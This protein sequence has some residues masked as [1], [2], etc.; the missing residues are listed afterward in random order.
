MPGAQG[1]DLVRKMRTDAE[2][3]LEKSK[4]FSNR[5][6]GNKNAATLFGVTCSWQDFATRM[7]NG[8]RLEQ[9]CLGGKVTQ[10]FVQQLLN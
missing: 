4:G 2:E 3:M 8:K 9:L 5:N 1:I 10:G 6:S 7:K